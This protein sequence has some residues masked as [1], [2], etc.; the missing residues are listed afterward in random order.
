MVFVGARAV[1]QYAS[2]VGFTIRQEGTAGAAELLGGGGIASLFAGGESQSD[3]DILYEYIQSQHLVTAVNDKFDLTGHYSANWEA[4]PIFSINADATVEE[5][6]SY[7]PR[8]VRISYDQATRLME[9]RVLAYDPQFAQDIATEIVDQSQDLINQL[10]AQARAD[11]IRYAEADLNEALERLKLS[12]EALIVFR[13]RTQIVDPET[14]LAG[15]A[16][17][18]EHASATVGRGA[19]RS[20][21]F[22]RDH[23]LERPADHPGKTGEL[24]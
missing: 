2:T 17:G 21:P 16:W 19:D 18:C 7:W 23:Q 5:L 14:D 10:N 24:T 6:V 4:D 9:L 22:V 8:I 11:T 13:T 1:D 15:A 12:R 3:T 20:G